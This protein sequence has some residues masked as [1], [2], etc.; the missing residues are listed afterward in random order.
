LIASCPNPSDGLLQTLDPRRPVR[1]RLDRGAHEGSQVDSVPSWNSS[2]RPWP[3]P[4]PRRRSHRRHTC[5]AARPDGRAA[6]CE[7]APSEAR[8]AGGARRPTEGPRRGPERPPDLD[9]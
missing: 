6:N 8:A 1:H 3:C 7:A 4:K 9:T 5:V 2:K